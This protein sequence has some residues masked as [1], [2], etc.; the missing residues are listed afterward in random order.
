MQDY[1]NTSEDDLRSILNS[2]A[3]NHPEDTRQAAIWELARRREALDRSTRGG[4]K[5]KPY[6]VSGMLP[7]VFGLILLVVGIIVAKE[8]YGFALT[9]TGT[10]VTSFSSVLMVILYVTGSITV[11]Y[12]VLRMKLRYGWIYILFGFVLTKWV[13]I[14]LGI[15]AAATSEP[16]REAK[17]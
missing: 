10:G 13:L 11:I 17:V 6:G 16:E 8:Q 1:T 2:P 4:V 15:Y 3:I 5:H 14:G 12:Y 9:G 7:L